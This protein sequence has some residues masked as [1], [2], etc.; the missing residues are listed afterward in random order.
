MQVVPQPV[1][2]LLGVVLAEPPLLILDVASQVEHSRLEWLLL[3]L[4]VT[5]APPSSRASC[6]SSQ[7]RV[8]AEI[9][10]VLVSVVQLGPTA[11]DKFIFK[12]CQN[13]SSILKK[14]GGGGG[15]VRLRMTNVTFL[16]HSLNETNELN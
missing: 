14:T 4:R 12:N 11:Q 6:R 15:G 7:A 8:E 5:L 2:H 13:L 10:R 1:Y 3:S 16:N 9:R